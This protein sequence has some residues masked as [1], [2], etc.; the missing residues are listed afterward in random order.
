LPLPGFDTTVKCPYCGAPGQEY[1]FNCSKCGR[2]LPRDIMKPLD[3]RDRRFCPM[4]GREMGAS[5]S[6]C[7]YCRS[8]ESY[9]AS[10]EYRPRPSSSGTVTLGGVLIL[11]SGVFAIGS[12][13]F[14]LALSSAIGAAGY[15]GTGF[16]TCCSFIIVLFGI[17]AMVGGY[18][19]ITRSHFSFAL[20]GGIL[21][22]LAGGFWIG[23]VLGLVGLVLIAVSR[24][25]FLD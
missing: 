21:G 1:L 8:M 4:C 10:H 14:S 25:E 7:G 11:L 18:F 17:A 12:G 15:S 13:I 3:Q 22:T 16:L 2:E 23:L 20:V 9:A 5:D 24:D 19:A 6:V